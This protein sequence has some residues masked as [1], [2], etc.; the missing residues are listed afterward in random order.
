MEN[1]ENISE[2]EDLLQTI[3]G[4]ASD[5]QKIDRLINFLIIQ[6]KEIEQQ[7]EMLQSIVNLIKVMEESKSN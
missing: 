6:N 4:M 5:S 2:A 1:S 7:G 3:K